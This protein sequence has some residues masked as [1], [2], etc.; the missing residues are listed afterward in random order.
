MVK[1]LLDEFPESF[2]PNNQQT[3]IL[4]KITQAFNEG[5]KFVVCCAPTG[6]GKSFIGKTLGNASREISD[7]LRDA[8]NDYSAYKRTHAGGY[9]F[10]DEALELEPAG[11]FTLTITKS[12]QDQYNSLFPDIEVLKGKSNYQCQVDTDQTVE[13]G[14][15]NHIDKMREEC[16][17]VNKCPYYNARNKAL[18]SK[19]ATLNYNMFFAL[20]PHLKRKEYIVCDEA[21]E[22]EDQIVK[23]F[24]CVINF[25]T[26]QK[27]KV[28]INPV[29][30][31]YNKLPAWINNMQS[32]INDVI[33]DLTDQ[34]LKD[35]KSKPAAL[36]E[37]KR[38]IG[39]LRSVSMKT[40]TLI[41]TWN[42]SEYLLERD[43]KSI[44][45]TPLK[46]DKLSARIFKHG[47]K[48]VLLSATI[49]DPANFCKTL[50]IDKFKYIEVGSTFNPANAPIYANTS[51]KLNYSNLK[52]NLPLITKQIKQIC[53]HHSN[54]KGI[55]H[56]QTNVITDYLK[57]NLKS[58]RVIYREL[59]VNN[60]D[61]LEQ[62]FNSDKPTIIASPSM[63][64]GVDL[65]DDL[66]RFQIII[67]APYLPTKDKRVERMMKMD[68]SWYINK[69]LC[70]LI[71]S[72]GRGI[73]TPKDHCVTYILDGA[74][75]ESIIRNKNKL[76]QYFIERFA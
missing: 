67:K 62:H 63:S 8:I 17:T 21:S 7:T 4:T 71:Q 31:E 59:G 27:C 26:L 55:I 66:A 14:P 47:E 60:Q 53:D 28:P 56:T 41:E 65:K 36:Q 13:Y 48:I 68:P 74:I 23:E 75:V 11:T 16:W 20:P 44:S 35:K 57:Q 34:L 69:M 18:S 61:I 51:V 22:L 9:A 70:S 32:N 76:P 38:I 49:I 73:R 37:K 6:S 40:S 45:F 39:A 25:E 46:V 43:T 24:T 10:E 1:N 29:P 42:D 50:G 54:E 5:Y 58:D 64:F 2:T 33:E 52:S 19:L 12:L 72:T 15:C 30:L 3:E